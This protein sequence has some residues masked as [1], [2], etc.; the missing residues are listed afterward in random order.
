ME[1]IEISQKIKIF[2]E[3]FG[4][5][6]VF[7]A[8][9]LETTPFGWIL[10]GG[11]IIAAA[12]FFSYPNISLFIK[13][14]IS[15]WLGMWFS[16]VAGYF[17]GKKTGLWLVRKLNQEKNAQKAKK[18][19]QKNG[20]FILTSSII[21]N[22]IR[23]WMAYIAGVGNY[24]IF[25]FLIYSAFASFSWVSLVVFIGFISGAKKAHIESMLS[26]MGSFSWIVVFIVI[27]FIILSIKREKANLKE[28][29]ENNKDK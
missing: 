27:V 16:L 8:S 9:F 17:L 10:P 6:T 29:N 20:A 22:L 18:L 25:S 14:L 1:T 13:I 19:L 24:P 21:A 11:L 26:K 28:K 3:N 15:A 7:F 4:G 12:S 23:F 2:L 5:L